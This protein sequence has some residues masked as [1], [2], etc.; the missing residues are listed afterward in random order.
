MINTSQLQGKYTETHPLV[1]ASLETQSRLQAELRKEL[2]VSVATLTKDLQIAEF[3][4][5]DREVRSHS[6]I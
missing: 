6:I 1:L 2:G 4:T 3:L 5:E